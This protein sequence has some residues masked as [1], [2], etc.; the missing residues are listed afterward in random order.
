MSR[1]S[2]FASLEKSSLC[3]LAYSVDK[4]GLLD[5]QDRLGRTS[6]SAFD[7]VHRL[8]KNE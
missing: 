1:P 5:Y 7:R 2:W 6:L 8:G 4:A 3:A